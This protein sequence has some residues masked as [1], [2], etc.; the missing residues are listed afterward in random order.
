MVRTV[1]EKQHSLSGETLSNKSK[2]SIF[3]GENTAEIDVLFLLAN[4]FGEYKL[5]YTVILELCENQLVVHS[6]VLAFCFL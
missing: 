5:Q 3:H 6:E 4:K 1:Q 2:Y